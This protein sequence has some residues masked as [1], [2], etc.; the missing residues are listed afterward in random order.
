MQHFS[1][2]LS[3]FLLRCPPNLIRLVGGLDGCTVSLCVRTV[4]VFKIFPLVVSSLISYLIYLTELCVNFLMIIGIMRMKVI[5]LR[6]P[7]ER[8][9]R[10]WFVHSVSIVIKHLLSKV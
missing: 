1:R 9:V 10:M 7:R 6:F 2:M 8:M 3:P 4:C 5:I